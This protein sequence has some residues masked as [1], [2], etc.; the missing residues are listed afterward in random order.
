MKPEY[1]I[2]KYYYRRLF[3]YTTVILHLVKSSYTRFGFNMTTTYLNCLIIFTPS[4]VM[5][6]AD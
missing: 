1:V 6:N 3:L 4:I 2:I 5:P